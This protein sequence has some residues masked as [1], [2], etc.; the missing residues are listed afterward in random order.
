MIFVIRGSLD[1]HK[2]I[3]N[4]FYKKRK[5]ANIEAKHD[6]FDK[7]NSNKREKKYQALI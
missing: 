3:K 5:T 6:A 7:L 2:D 1:K 4:I